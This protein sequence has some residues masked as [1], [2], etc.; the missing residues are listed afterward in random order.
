MAPE[1]NLLP[2][3][4]RPSRGRRSL[5]IVLGIAFLLLVIY[6]SFQYISLNKTIQS[7]QTEEQQLQAEKAELEESIIVL[8]TPV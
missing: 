1:I 8:D 6:L 4:E 7:L 2:H 5:T 3:I